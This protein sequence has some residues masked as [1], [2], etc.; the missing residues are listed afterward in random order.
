LDKPSAKNIELVQRHW[1]GK[2]H[3]V[4]EGIHLMTLLWTE[5]ERHGPV[6]Y[7]L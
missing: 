3:A 5:G 7:R 6:D 4:V 2:H 1:S